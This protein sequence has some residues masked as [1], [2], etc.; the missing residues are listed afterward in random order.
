MNLNSLLIGTI[1][2]KKRAPVEEIIRKM[3]GLLLKKD[4]FSFLLT[5]DNLI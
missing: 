1:I 5:W 2:V 4:G 3:E